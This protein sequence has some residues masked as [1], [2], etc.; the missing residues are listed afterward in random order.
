MFT[1]QYSQGN[2]G[3]WSKVTTFAPKFVGSALDQAISK[4]LKAWGGLVDRTQAC[5]AHLTSAVRS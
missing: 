1:V 5:A 4:L 2:E 3:A